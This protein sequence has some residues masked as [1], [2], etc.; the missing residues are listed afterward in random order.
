MILVLLKCLPLEKEQTFSTEKFTGVRINRF[1]RDS[2]HGEILD[3]LCT[4]GLPE[5]KKMG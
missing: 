4:C 3:F 1:P 2:D 5:N